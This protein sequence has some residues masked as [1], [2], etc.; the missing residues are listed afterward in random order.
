MAS[1]CHGMEPKQKGIH[2]ASTVGG[3]DVYPLVHPQ[4]REA[5]KR[6]N[7]S[8]SQG[9]APDLDEV[10]ETVT[11]KC[12]RKASMY[13]DLMIMKENELMKEN[14]FELRKEAIAVNKRLEQQKEKE[15]TLQILQTNTIGYSL[16]MLVFHE[17]MLAAA[18][19]KYL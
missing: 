8:K 3:A 16:K 18:L 12:I 11:S 17:K 7:R 6:E 19:T 5:V 9:K 14:E 15:C 1:T 13:E 4:G 10:V 2:N